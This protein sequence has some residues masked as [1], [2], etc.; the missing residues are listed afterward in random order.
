MTHS[1]PNNETLVKKLLS[2]RNWQFDHTSNMFVKTMFK[3]QILLC[4]RDY[5]RPKKSYL[6]RALSKKLKIKASSTVPRINSHK[7]T[8]CTKLLECHA[9]LRYSI[10]SLGGSTDNV[11][12]TLFVRFQIPDHKAHSHPLDVGHIMTSGLL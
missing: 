12:D 3:T 2:L 6:K 7:K 8:I 1:P 4:S 9:R 11:E 10:I 5:V